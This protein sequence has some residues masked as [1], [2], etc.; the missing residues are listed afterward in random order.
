MLAFGFDLCTF[1]SFPIYFHPI[2][3]RDFYYDLVFSHVG[4]FRPHGL[5]FYYHLFSILFISPHLFLISLVYLSPTLVL[6]S[7]LVCLVYSL[8]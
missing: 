4:H 7:L 1:I 5:L 6:V 8:V 3:S 2:V